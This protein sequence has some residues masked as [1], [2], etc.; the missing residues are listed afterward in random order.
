MHQRIRG[1]S[2]RRRVERPHHDTSL[3]SVF[4]GVF[5]FVSILMMF[6]NQKR[7]DKANKNNSEQGENND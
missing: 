6:E 3:G 2:F 7:F 4:I 1:A 5:L